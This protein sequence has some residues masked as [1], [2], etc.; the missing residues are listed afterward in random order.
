M[1]RMTI[2]TEK[3][4]VLRALAVS[5]AILAAAAG[6]VLLLSFGV[7]SETERPQ[8]PSPALSPPLAPL[9][10]QI[11]SKKKSI[12]LFFPDASTGKLREQEREIVESS[13]VSGQARQVIELLLKGTAGEDFAPLFPASSHLLGLFV[14]DEG[15]AY[16]DFSDEIQMPAGVEEFLG[17]GALA[18]TLKRNPCA[19]AC[20]SRSTVMT[21]RLPRH[22][23]I[24]YL[25]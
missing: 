25:W 18:I 4:A 21:L 11:P 17:P 24:E 5:A 1:Q 14:D 19:S 15:Q 16:L 3:G 6:C 20:R 13:S 9:E 7:R 22:L 23:S 10:A 2:R 12:V 8:L